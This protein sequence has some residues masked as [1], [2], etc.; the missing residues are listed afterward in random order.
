MKK[1]RFYLKICVLLLLL[2]NVDFSQ[3]TLPQPTPTDS[4]IYI[5]TEEV[6]LNVS[7]LKRNGDFVSNL[8]PEDLVVFENGRLNQATSVRQIPA[9]VLIV[10]DVGNEIPYS[11]RNKITAETARNLVSALKDN[12]SIAAL[13]YGDKVE[14]LS[15]WT[16]DKAKLNKTLVDN[17]LGFGKHSV[18]NQAIQTAL[19]FF[20]LTPLENRHL[21]LITDGVDSFDKEDSK[22]L[23]MQRVL[24]SDINVHVISY[25]R[26]Q[27]QAISRTKIVSFGSG[28]KSQKPPSNDV[29]QAGQTGVGATVT[30]NLDTEMMQHR[31]KILDKIQI[32]EQFL[33]SLAENTNG[34][35]FLPVTADEMVDKMGNLAKYIDSQY[36]VT[37]TPK[38]L[39]EEAADSREIRIVNVTSRRAD[40]DIQGNRKYILIKEN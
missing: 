32:S 29:S 4:T 5:S 38:D 7:A 20:E 21:I 10:L 9:N 8:M 11:K 23:I 40:V 25:T 39:P 30:I 15:D 13:Q 34:E 3:D 18:F 1:I 37:Y 19:D 31:K 17:N 35:I 24:T 6:K 27:K 26:L 2:T 22:K 16:K 28:M 12:D 33:M 36:V 14:I